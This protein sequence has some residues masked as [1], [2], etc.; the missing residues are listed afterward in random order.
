[1]LKIDRSFVQQLSVGRDES[2]LVRS[3]V[4]LGQTMRLQVVAEGVATEA[5]RERLIELG[6]RLG[7]GYLFSPAVPADAMTRIAS[8]RLLAAG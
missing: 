2:A 3:V 8:I 4:R 1:M 7:Q 5:Q 6:A